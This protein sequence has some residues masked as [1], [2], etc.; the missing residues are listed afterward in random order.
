MPIYDVKSNGKGEFWFVTET[1][2]TYSI[3]MT[4]NEDILESAMCNVYDLSFYKI[5]NEQGYES[6][7]IPEFVKET[8]FKILFQ[9]LF[10]DCCIIWLCEVK[11]LKQKYRHH[12]F[13][14][15]FNEI[16]RPFHEK[17]DIHMQ[18]SD[19]YASLVIQTDNKNYKEIIEEFRMMAGKYDKR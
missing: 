11:D 13:K 5:E 14:K 15:W 18:K 19:F 1:N 12:L 2:V 17:I 10:E 6:R 4:K 8:I 3:N 9:Y 7:K 16:K